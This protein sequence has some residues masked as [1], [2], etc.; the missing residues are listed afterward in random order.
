V[1][2]LRAFGSHYAVLENGA[3]KARRA[4]SLTHLSRFCPL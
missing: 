3:T 1:F 2:F 4:R